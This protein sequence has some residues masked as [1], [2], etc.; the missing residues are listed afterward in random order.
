V[1]EKC[2][3]KKLNNYLLSNNLLS[4]LQ[5]GFRAGD[6]T[7]FQLTDIYNTISAALDA[8]KEIRIVY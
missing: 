8:G 2:V 5:S 7:V 1:F 6:S 4:P 3:N